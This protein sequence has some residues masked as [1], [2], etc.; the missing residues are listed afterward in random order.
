MVDRRH[1]QAH[2][3][4]RQTVAFD[5]RM[6]SWSPEK[7]NL[8]VGGVIIYQM[9]HYLRG[10]FKTQ[11]VTIEEVTWEYINRLNCLVNFN[12][13]QFGDTYRLKSPGT[14]MVHF[15]LRFHWKPSRRVY[16]SPV[17]EDLREFINHVCHYVFSL[18]FWK[19][20]A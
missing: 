12:Q 20:F 11:S 3:G 1:S 17:K 15:A 8:L 10:L 19:S 13:T 5:C 7:A 4:S 2:I 18:N 16:R 14:S 6:Y 9:V